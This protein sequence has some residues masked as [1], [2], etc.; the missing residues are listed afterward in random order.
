MSEDLTSRF[1]LA[2][3]KVVTLSK[4]PDDLVKLQLY[5][6]YKQSLEG[7]CKG[8]RPSAFNVVA[9]AKYDSWKTLKGTSQEAAMQQ[10]ID[11]V[12]TLAEADASRKTEQ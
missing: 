11:L 3:E 5:A 1:R 10:Y 7:D 9:R 4:A 12:N 6:L 8:N 2:A